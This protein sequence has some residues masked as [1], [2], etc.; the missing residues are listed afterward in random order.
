MAVTAAAMI[1]VF[2]LVF[3]LLFISLLPYPR[4]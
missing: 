4:K 3:V 2:V 1:H